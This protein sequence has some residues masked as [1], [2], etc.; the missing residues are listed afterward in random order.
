MATTCNASCGQGPHGR[1]VAAPSVSTSSRTGVVAASPTM[2]P[3][4]AV[5]TQSTLTT[6][7]AMTITCMV[8]A[9]KRVTHRPPS[10][11]TSWSAARG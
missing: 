6:V 9:A 7:N 1:S 2:M 10:T 8:R 4:S 3:E 5:V 11:T